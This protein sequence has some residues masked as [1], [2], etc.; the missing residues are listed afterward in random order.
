[1]FLKYNVLR[2]RCI[3]WHWRSRFVEIW[4][5][6]QVKVDTPEFYDAEEKWKSKQITLRGLQ[7]F[8]LKRAEFSI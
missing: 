4:R 2:L 8:A 7:K 1:M 5:K 6:A 3:Q